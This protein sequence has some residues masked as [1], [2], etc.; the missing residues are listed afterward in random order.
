MRK[1]FTLG[2]LLT[3][4]TVASG[5][6]AVADNVCPVFLSSYLVSGFS[7]SMVQGGVT[8]TVSNFTYTFSASGS[9]MRFPASNIQVVP[10]QFSIGVNGL[11]I[12]PFPSIDLRGVGEESISI[13]YT[14][15]F[16][17]ASR[18]GASWFIDWLTTSN[19][20]HPTGDYSNRATE[21]FSGLGVGAV[22]CPGT[23]CSDGFSGSGNF[24]FSPLP[25]RSVVVTDTDTITTGS[26]DSIDNIGVLTNE[27]L[28][29]SPEPSFAVPFATGMLAMLW[30]ALARRK[31]GSTA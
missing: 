11:Q 1:A 15:T 28:A 14:A 13:G 19:D 27:F 24:G 5:I 25:I 17:P 10:L 4:L 29:A 20:G 26:P 22:T 16:S 23:G 30:L 8:E 3:G 18:I 31:A 7:C 12:H 9:G 6:R 21:S 2:L